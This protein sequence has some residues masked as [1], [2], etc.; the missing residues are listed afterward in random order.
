LNELY[1]FISE[2]FL[3]RRTFSDRK[4][5]LASGEGGIEFMHR[6]IAAEASQFQYIDTNFISQRTDGQGYHQNELSYGFQFTQLRLPMG[7]VLEMVYDPIK[8]DRQLFPELAPGT[9]RTAESYSMDIFDFGATDQKA[10]GAR[11][12]NITCVMQDG[13]ESY[14][15]VSNVYD[16]KTGAIKDGS[17][18][19]SNNKELGIY[20]E[21]S[22]GL[23]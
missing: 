6:L 4:I 16:F 22:G 5:K 15:S 2:I 3:T 12:D 10:D 21:T 7:Y 8:D 1:E 18:A 14:F 20:R 17:N 11:P 19:Y 13:V 23:N 9:N